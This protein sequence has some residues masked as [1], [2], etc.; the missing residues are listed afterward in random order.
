MAEFKIAALAVVEAGSI[1]H[2]LPEIHAS[3]GVTSLI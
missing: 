1:K 3:V 2:P